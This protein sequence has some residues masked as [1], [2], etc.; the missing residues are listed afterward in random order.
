MASDPVITNPIKTRV[1]DLNTAANG[2][3]FDDEFDQ[4][5]ENFNDLAVEISDNI[6]QTLATLGAN[7]APFITKSGTITKGAGDSLDIPEHS[8]VV[9]RAD[10]TQLI[11]L[12]IPLQDDLAI[13]SAVLDNS[14]TNFI[15]V[16]HLLTAPFF[17]ITVDDVAPVAG[18]EAQL[19]TFVGPGGGPYV[20]S[21]IKSPILSGR[22]IASQPP[23]EILCKSNGAWPKS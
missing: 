10:S 18:K 23:S 7:T 6:G 2:D 4:V 9:E 19:D 1:W 14:T 3:F 21:F 16:A 22:Q 5:Y 17:V 8:V 13:P 15:K 20:F 11:R 12:T